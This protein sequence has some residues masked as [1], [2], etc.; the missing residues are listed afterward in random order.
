MDKLDWGWWCARGVDVG[1][2][3]GKSGS[4]LITRWLRWDL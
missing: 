3:R 4:G 2:G 1:N